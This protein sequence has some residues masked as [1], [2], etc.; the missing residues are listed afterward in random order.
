MAVITISR[1]FGAGGITVGEIVAQK[2]GYKFY[3][4]E[5][6]QMLAKEAKVST[7]WVED[8]EK[9][10][11]G[12]L[13][14][15]LSQVVP[16]SMVERILDEKRGYI[17]EEIYVDLLQLIIKKIADDGNAV[18]I[19]RGGQ[20]IL[21]DRPDVYHILLV[22][23]K[24][25]RIKFIEEKYGLRPKRAIQTVNFDDKRRVNLYRKFGREDYDHPIHY[26]LV[27]N[28]SE[29]SREKAADLVCKLVSGS[30]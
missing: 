30:A 19:G 22:A 14:K 3:D 9:Q 11:G 10:A 29:I 2:L 13:Q 6:I 28:T 12:A 15:F 17:D 24:L 5:I 18:I 1:Q 23:D 8:L 7:H 21:A 20:Y 16:K 4:N 26:H 25:D 27:I